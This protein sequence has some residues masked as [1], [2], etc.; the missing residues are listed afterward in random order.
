MKGHD[1]IT[2]ELRRNN[3]DGINEKIEKTADEIDANCWLLVQM[4]N[5]C[6]MFYTV[7]KGGL[8]RIIKEHYENV[9]RKKPHRRGYNYGISKRDGKLRPVLNE[10]D[11]GAM[12]KDYAGFDKLRSI[13][14][15]PTKL[16]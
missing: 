10:R 3:F 15:Q 13:L 14:T 4:R 6:N 9:V 16:S 2:G 11:D 5:D 8:K 12:L 1:N 7:D